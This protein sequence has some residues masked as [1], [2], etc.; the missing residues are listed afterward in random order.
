MRHLLTVGILIMFGLGNGACS[1]SSAKK[2]VKQRKATRRKARTQRVNQPFTIQPDRVI[3]G[4][5]VVRAVSPG[6]LLVERKGG[7]SLSWKLSRDVSAF[8]SLSATNFPILETLYTMALEEALLDIR[9]ED[10]AF[11]AGAKWHGVWTRD[12]SYSIHLALALIHPQASEKSLRVKVNSMPEVI[13]DTGTGGSWPISTDRVVWAIAAWELYLATGNTRWLGWSYQVLRNT[14]RRDRHVAFDRESGLYFGESSF[15]DWRSQTYPGWMEPIDIFQSKA[16]GTNVLHYRLLSILAEMARLL[17]RPAGEA[18]RWKKQAVLLKQAINR[19]LWLEEKKYYSLY[20]YPNLHGVLCDKSDT[21][22]EALTVLC[23]VADKQRA[24]LVVSNTPAVHFGMPCIHPQQPSPRP[25]HNKGIW[26]FV[27]AYF[28]WAAARC[29][30]EQATTHCLRSMTRAAAIFRTHK[31]NF[32]Y[33]TG[34]A[35]GTAINSDRQLWSVAGYLALVYRVLFGMDLQPEGLAL[36]PFVPGLIQTPLVLSNFPYRKARLHITIL[37]SGSRVASLQINGKKRPV[38]YRIPPTT[39][40]NL[41][42]VLRLAGK[43]PASGFNLRPTS[44]IA[45][46][47]TYL[48]YSLKQGRVS[49]RWRTYRGAATSLLFRNG[50]RHKSLP[51]SGPKARYG[52]LQEAFA[53]DKQFAFWRYAVRILDKDGLPSNMSQ[54][55]MVVPGNGR[56]MV[57]AESADHNSTVAGKHS[58][59]SGSGYVMLEGKKGERIKFTVKVKQAGRYLLRFRYGNGSGPINTDNKCA[60]RSLRVD[61]KDCATVVLPQR[62][63]WASWGYSNPIMLDL[64]TGSHTVE[65]LYDELDRN[66]NGNV[67]RAAIDRL[68]LIKYRTN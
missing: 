50:S 63:F 52:R 49:L 6:E 16:L 26:P 13:Q 67:N 22:G 3:Q 17:R 10:G 37:G 39:R 43:H 48:R 64:N 30:N 38:G 66:M 4:E 51:V 28:A 62:G 59:F 21:L 25:Y 40:G 61:G 15:L 53:P 42:I 9:K 12:I 29:G 32:V 14:A 31:E 60:I 44:E 33:D 45:P 34:R 27:E 54:L 7:R 56:I 20:R 46:D 55:V 8:P 57:Q 2:P 36:R 68:E 65:M 18:A 24:A 23:G 19:L 1:G 5:Q 41:R 58:G 11:M 35:Y 47:E